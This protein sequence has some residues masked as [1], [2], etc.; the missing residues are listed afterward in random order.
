VS[1]LEGGHEP[2]VAT[3][4]RP[5]RTGETIPR[6]RPVHEGRIDF[7]D[8]ARAIGIVLV[9]LGH[10]PGLPELGSAFIFAFH[11][12]L[13]FFLSGFVVS[14]NRLTMATAHRT[15][16]LARS[17]LLP[18]LFYFVVAY[19]Y[20]LV[21]KR[22]GLR[23]MEFEALP[24]WDPLAGFIVGNPDSLYVDVVLWFFPCLFITAAVH[25]VACK[26][27]SVR[28]AAVL[29]TV[30]AIAFVIFHTDDS[31]RWLWSADCAVVAIAFYA[32]GAAFTVAKRPRVAMRPA[33]LGSIAIGAAALC[34]ALAYVTGHVDLSHLAFG[35]YPVL[36][37]PM[38]LI[39]ISGTLAIS[40]LLPASRVRRWLSLNTLVIFPLHFLMF[41]LFTGIAIEVFGSDPSFKTSTGLC[42]LYTLLALLLCWPASVAL[43]RFFPWLFHQGRARASDP[44]TPSS[45][46]A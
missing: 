32:I 44:S 23:A 28:A 15:V 1:P 31:S 29:L 22:H 19:L 12:P 18:Y 14:A 2:H 25:H 37:V 7:V 39:G 36:Y 11:M 43:R 3:L 30:L 45:L 34:L 38:G 4:D 24:W 41:S 27:M 9:V 42:V 17:L 33:V 16:L 46:P 8:N 13:F 35:A 5:A 6:S 21:A 20:W 40:H 26:L 10:S